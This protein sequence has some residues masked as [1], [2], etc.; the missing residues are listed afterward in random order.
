MGFEALST[1]G[2][3]PVLVGS[4]PLL[5]NV[6]CLGP[7]GQPS[8]TQLGVVPQGTVVVKPSLS[9]DQAQGQRCTYTNGHAFPKAVCIF[10][11]LSFPFFL[12]QL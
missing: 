11:F 7:T 8:G 9:P 5:S 6:G 1:A 10:A 12:L 3:P 4:N 2:P